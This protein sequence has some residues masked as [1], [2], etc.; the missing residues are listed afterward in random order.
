MCLA[1][2]FGGDIG[3]ESNNVEGVGGLESIQG[4]DLLANVDYIHLPPQKN[5]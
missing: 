5:V 2:L 4:G 1:M 3:M